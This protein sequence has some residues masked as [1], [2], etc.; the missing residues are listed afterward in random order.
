MKTAKPLRTKRKQNLSGFFFQRPQGAPRGLLLH[1]ILHRVSVGPVHGYEIAQDIEEKTDGAWRPAPGS[2]YPM[3][4]KLTSQGLIRATQTK[5]RRGSDTSQRT[6]EIT[7]KGAKCLGQAKEMFASAGF[8]W[9]S[10]RRLFIELMDSD[11]V[12]KFLVEGSKAGF[13]MSQEL[14]NTKITKLSQKEGEFAL[15]E[16]ILNL[17]KQLDWAERKLGELGSSIVT[18]PNLG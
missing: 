1:Y 9:T 14:V 18:T 7:P 17:Q 11:Q 2:I 10:M 4:K 3:L 5:T 8:R 13:Q 6:Y 12:A 16:Y 15:K